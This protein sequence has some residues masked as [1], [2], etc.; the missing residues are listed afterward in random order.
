M[1]KAPRS[2]HPLPFASI[3]LAVGLVIAFAASG[4]GA[5]PKPPPAPPPTLAAPTPER[6]ASPS[7]VQAEIGGMNEEAMG[8]AFNS[9]GPSIQEC[10]EAGS[11][12]VKTLGGHVTF[13]L[14]IAM[15][16]AV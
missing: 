13:S 16:G 1:R 12:K 7:A 5:E 6:Q 2:S 15:D 11:G 10:V 9:L 3:A 8:R 4:C 14:R